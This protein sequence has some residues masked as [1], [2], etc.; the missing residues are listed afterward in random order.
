MDETVVPFCVCFIGFVFAVH[1]LLFIF[2]SMVY[3]DTRR[4]ADHFGTG[5][6]E[7][8]LYHVEL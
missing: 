4:C 6:I 3:K 7:N 2:L 5:V 1:V 8:R